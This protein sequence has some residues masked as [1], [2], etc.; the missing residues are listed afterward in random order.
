MTH[1][2]GQPARERPSD[3]ARLEREL[4]DARKTIKALL[5]Q[6]KKLQDQQAETTRAY[7]KTVANMVEIVRENTSLARECESWKS[8]AMGI[9]PSLSLDGL[10]GAISAEEAQAIR[11]A[12]ARLHH[13]DAGGDTERMKA[14]NATLDAIENRERS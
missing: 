8:R 2:D 6:M 14:W 9:A 11:R 4:D 3:C 10:P 12:I 13:P 1:H 5:R 7:N